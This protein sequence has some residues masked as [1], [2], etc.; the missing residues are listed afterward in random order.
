MRMHERGSACLAIHKEAEM[1][2]QYKGSKLFHLVQFRS[3]GWFITVEVWLLSHP[4]LLPAKE[5][6]IHHNY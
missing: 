1:V 2:P 6:Y 4:Y 3:S 5:I